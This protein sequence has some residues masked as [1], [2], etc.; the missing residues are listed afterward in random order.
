MIREVLDRQKFGAFWTSSLL[1]QEAAWHD[2]GNGVELITFGSVNWLG[3]IKVRWTHEPWPE[4]VR[5]FERNS[6]G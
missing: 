3:P 6:R 5:F 2:M 1:V 4:E